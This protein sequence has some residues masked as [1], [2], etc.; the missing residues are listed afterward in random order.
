M[1][2][3]RLIIG[4]AIG[5]V[6]ALIAAVVVAFIVTGDDDDKSSKRKKKP[7][8]DKV[9]E[10]VEQVGAGPVVATYGDYEI[11][12]GEY[13]YFY[14]SLYNQARSTAQ[15]YDQYYSGMG[16]QYFDVNVAPA[17]QTC[18]ETELPDGVVT[19]ADYF[20]YC[21]PER[22]F[23][24]EHLCNEAMDNISSNGGFSIS[25]EEYEEITEAINETLAEYEDQA[26]IADETID[27][28]ISSLMGEYVTTEVYRELLEKEFVA[29]LYLSWY[30]EF[31]CEAI[32]DAEIEDYYNENKDDIDVAEIRVYGISYASGSK[33]TAKSMAEDFVA[34]L[35][36]G[37]SF[38]DL[39]IEFAS[40]SQ[41]NAYYDDSA[42]L[43]KY[44]TKSSL[45]AIQTGLGEWVFDASRVAGDAYIIDLAQSQAYFV[46]MV[47]TPASKNTTPTSVGVRHILIEVKKTTEIA[48]GS[49]V[50]L[51]QETIEL[52][53]Q[54]AYAKA[55]EVVSLWQENGATEQ[56]F[57]DLVPLYTNDSGSVST[58]GLYEDIDY[59]SSYVTEFLYW[60]LAPHN[61]G[62]VEIIET[63]YGYHV[64]YYVGGDTTPVWSAEIRDTLGTEAYEKYY[65]DLAKDIRDNVERDEDA[66]EELRGKAEIIIQRFL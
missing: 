3:K 59:E 57:I 39:A 53:K 45:E 4:T 14:M 42:T 60:S 48:D 52:N 47:E 51:P 13:N 22:A 37:S 30:Q 21:A 2:N 58:G 40:E 20:A 31:S 56:A 65:L 26:E 7:E 29:E 27:E 33:D 46:I 35:N 66:I 28:Y 34:K 6:V 50:E 19:W 36:K 41:K 43:M 11:T 8:K 64:M 55:R 49:Q 63:T 23:L 38:Y 62:D 17:D 61:F 25:G 15:Q 44:Q 24:V 32:T 9:E 12:A 1:K 16:S 54:N 18:P 5:V 10:Q